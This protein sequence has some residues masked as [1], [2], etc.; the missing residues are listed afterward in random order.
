MMAT[1]TYENVLRDAQQLTPEEQQRLRETLG[2]SRGA[3][4]VSLRDLRALLANGLGSPR[5]LT[6]QERAAVDTWLAETEQ[7]AERIGAAWKDE[8]SAVEAVKE[9]RRDL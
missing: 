4:V 3:R 7:L 5:P 1:V 8:M 9:Q 6:E 2:A